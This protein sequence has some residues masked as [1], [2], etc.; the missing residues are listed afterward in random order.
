MA[1]NQDNLGLATQNSTIYTVLDT[2]L[3]FCSR[4]IVAI[5]HTIIILLV[6][7]SKINCG[8]S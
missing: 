5:F 1:D 6:L 4:R 7:V 8:R 2:I 3:F